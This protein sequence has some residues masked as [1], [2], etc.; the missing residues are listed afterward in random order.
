MR[1]TQ[2][3]RQW[4]ILRLI[5]SRKMGI[6]GTELADELEVP[7]RTIYRDLEAIQEAGFPLYTER[8]GTT[9][10][11][12]L[13]EKFKKDFPLPLTLT[14]L[15]ALHMSCDVLSIFEGTVFQASIESL[16]KKVKASLTPETLQYLEGLS[17]RIKVNF[18][19]GRTFEGFKNTV[20]CISDATAKRNRVEIIYR[21]ASTARTTHRKV[22]PFQV[23]A[24]NG[25]FYL[26][27]F[28]HVR[29]EVRTFAME[30]IK[31]FSILDETFQMREDFNLEEY[32]KGAF[33]LMTGE[34]KKIRIRVA[35]SAAHVI[36]ERKWHP[37]QQLQELLDGGIEI[38]LDAPINYEIISW[39]LGFGPAAEVL[40][41]SELKSRIA[42]DL[43]TAASQYRDLSR[44]QKALPERIPAQLS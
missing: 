27:G 34:P 9:S 4:K 1:G 31:N 39:I 21:A 3:A 2:L 44:S 42:R 15:M 12:K 17:G 43:E 33:Q 16:F 35:A 19:P 6:T 14:E 36:R 8:E 29:R 23:L 26:I 22:D 28:C 38:S 10:A 7:L 20:K 5:E 13:L 37:S 41:P 32:L 24:M 11:W 40:Q 30:R 25:G 18:G